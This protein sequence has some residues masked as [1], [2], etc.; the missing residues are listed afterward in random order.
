MPRW[1]NPKDF[2]GKCLPDG[3][4]AL[5]IEKYFPE[6]VKSYEEPLSLGAGHELL[7]SVFE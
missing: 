6:S 2:V 5:K 7:V 1:K 3:V 4:N